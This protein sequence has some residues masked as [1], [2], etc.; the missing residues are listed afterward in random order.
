MF[1]LIAC[2]TTLLLA[3]PGKDLIGLIVKGND[4]DTVKIRKLF[5]LYH[6]NK[7]NEPQLA[8]SAAECAA[9]IAV[10]KNLELL[11]ARAL[12]YM[13]TV[14]YGMDRY[15]EALEHYLKAL[16]LYEKLD[17]KREQGVIL[18]NMGNLFLDQELPDQALP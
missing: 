16:Q 2:S 3:Q 18:N 7:L 9:N 10:E 5:G 11:H 15:P 17:K 1:L 13:G 14:C 6:D 8:L 12:G 4:A